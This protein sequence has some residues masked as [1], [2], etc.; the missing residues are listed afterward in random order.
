MRMH[1]QTEAYLNQWRDRQRWDLLSVGEAREDSRNVQIEQAVFSEANEAGR[2]NLRVEDVLIPEEGRSI[3]IR[4]YRPS[5]A[6]ELPPVIVFFH[7]GGFVI[8]D[9]DTHDQLCREISSRVAAVVVSVGYRLAPEHRYPSAVDDSVAATKWIADHARDMGWDSSRIA[10]VGDSAGGNLAAVVAAI[11]NSGSGP[12]ICFQL[13]IYPVTDNSSAMYDTTS[14]KEFGDGLVLTTEALHWFQ[15]QYFGA[16]EARRSEPEAS[17]LLADA[18]G[19]LPPTL[20]QI[21]ELD[22]IADSVREY[23]ERL[24]ESGVP[25][26]TSTYEGQMHAFVTMGKYFDAAFDAVDEAVGA[27]R[28]ALGS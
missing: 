27:L 3:P 10:L 9:L 16:G 25:V 4:T 1:P 19:N 28:S 15:N 5:D 26:T 6:S 8:G 12:K 23:A 24:Q 22:P 14:A 17:P 7:G 21:A 20:I 13:L 18:F 11:H 2:K